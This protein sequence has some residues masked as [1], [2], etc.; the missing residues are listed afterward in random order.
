[1]ILAANTGRSWYANFADDVE[2]QKAFAHFR[3]KDLFTV[4]GQVIAEKRALYVTTL[5]DCLS[6]DSGGVFE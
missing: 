6:N 4:A 3:S 2:A 1:M 5:P